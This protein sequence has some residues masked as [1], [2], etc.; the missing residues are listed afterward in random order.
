[1]CLEIQKNVVSKV[2]LDGININSCS[3]IIFVFIT[4]SMCYLVCGE[5]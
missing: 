1:M 5:V 3:L 2:K 4:T